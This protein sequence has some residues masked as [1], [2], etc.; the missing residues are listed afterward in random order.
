[1]IIL[2]DLNY[3]LVANSNELRGSDVSYR[4]EHERYRGWLLEL[5]RLM[6]PEAIAIVTIRDAS[7][8][9]WTLARIQS[10]LDWQP[11]LAVFNEQR[12]ITP[13]NFKRWA[14]KNVI[15]PRYGSDGS[16]FIAVESNLDTHSMYA[17]FG[18]RGLKAFP[19]EEPLGFPTG[20]STG[21]SPLTQGLTHGHA[22]PTETGSL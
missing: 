10:Q 6:Q 15:F 14:L 19:S 8:K 11:D 5:L 21:S 13:Q 22:S 1:M 2:L 17:D 9:E 4:K 3:T 7:W 16:R 18:I 20:L 12:N